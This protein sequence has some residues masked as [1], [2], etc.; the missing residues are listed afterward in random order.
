M[1][2]T[3]AGPRGAGLLFCAVEWHLAASTGR[4]SWRRRCYS[5]RAAG[6]E[7]SERR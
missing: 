6:L 1:V 3:V 5:V 7:R 4:L 2:R